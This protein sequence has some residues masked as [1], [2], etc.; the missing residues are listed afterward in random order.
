VTGTDHPIVLLTDFGT[1]NAFVGM[2][3]G[4]I[5]SLNPRAVVVDL[6]HGSRPQDIFQGALYLSQSL[7]CFPARTI[8]CAVVDPGVGSDRQAVAIQT[9]NHVLVGPDNGILWAAARQDTIVTGVYL[10]DPWFFRHPV[11]ATF[12]GR[13]IFAPV[14]AHLSL[15]YGVDQL[16]D[17]IPDPCRQLVRLTLPVP[18]R[19]GRVLVLTVL[20]IDTFGNITLNISGEDFG[21]QTG[22]GF[23]LVIGNTRISRVFKTYAL[24]PDAHPF[25][26]QASSGYMEVALK[27]GHAAQALEVS[28]QDRADLILGPDA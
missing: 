23:C 13:D 5:L 26:L 17:R 3:K 12:H 27:N 25:L 24:A 28:C 14:A 6:C 11:C 21:A 19:Q 15:G 16:G 2:M 4:V 18:E 1:Q 9:R 7:A 8:F 10:T 22:H 20:D